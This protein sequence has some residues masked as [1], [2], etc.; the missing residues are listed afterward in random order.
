MATTST[1]FSA[2]HSNGHA[3]N[4]PST[5]PFANTNNQTIDL[6]GDDD[7][8]DEDM[9]EVDTS[10]VDARNSKRPRIGV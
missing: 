6:T 1:A 8:D 7:D 10:A 4:I 2:V 9:D 5:S 3:Q